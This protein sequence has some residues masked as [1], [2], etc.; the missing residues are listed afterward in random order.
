[1]RHSERRKRRNTIIFLFILVVFMFG[2]FYYFS[3]YINIKGIG[4]SDGNFKVVIT[5]VSLKETAGLSLDNSKV[6]SISENKIEFYP[7]LSNSNESITYSVTVE[8]QGAL[9]AKYKFT[10]TL[11][12]NNLNIN[13]K[14][15]TY[16]DWSNLK[17]G[18]SNQFDVTLRYD[19]DYPVKNAMAISTL[20]LTLE[21]IQSTNDNIETVE[22]EKIDSPTFE[23]N[24]ASLRITY[25]KGCESKYKCTYQKDNGSE[26]T[27]DKSVID[28]KFST[29]GTVTAKV[30][31][32][33]NVISNSYN[34]TVN[35]V[36]M[37][38]H[39]NSSNDFHN[40]KYKSKISYVEFLSDISIPAGVKHWDVSYAKNGSVVAY[41][42]DDNE[43]GYKLYIGGKNGVIS[44]DLSYLFYNFTNLKSANISKLNTENSASMKGTFEGCAK[45]TELDLRTFN[46]ANTVIMNDMFKDCTN[47]KTIYVSN[48]FVTNQVI[49]SNNMFF[50]CV[51]LIGQNKM[52]YNANALNKDYANFVNG[53]FQ[54]I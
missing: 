19:G 45:L 27:A 25:P 10:P 21:S 20:I 4:S 52:T 40:I 7:Y 33:D 26:V 48:N 51:S 32:K 31:Y 3:N 9:D 2:G 8:N 29:S 35:P 17:S 42:L 18:D 11:D 36:M 39:D 38:W 14:E 53:Y 28:V 44:K 46:T 22:Q 47:L 34:I 23:E 12:E 6:P 5:D 13:F 43:G 24:G 50:G 37:I 54:T 1:M 41:V 16:L 15:T 30:I 49:S